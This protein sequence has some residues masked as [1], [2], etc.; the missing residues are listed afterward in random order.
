MKFNNGQDWKSVQSETGEFPVYGSGGKFGRATEF[1]HNGE[2]VL[3]GRKGTIDKPIY[4]DGKFWTVDTMFYATP[5]SKNTCVKYIYYWASTIEFVTISTNTALPSVTSTDLSQLRVPILSQ[6]EQVRIAHYLDRETAEIDAAVADLDRYVE[7][8]ATR[9]QLV[10]D[11]WFKFPLRAPS[12]ET[13]HSPTRLGLA[14]TLLRRGIS[15]KYADSGIPVVN[16]KCVRP[17]HFID[18]SNCR[19]HEKSKPI[20]PALLIQCGDI[21]INS[22]GT[23]TLGRS[24]LVQDIFEETTW[25]SHVTLLRPDR[26]VAHPKY[27]SWYIASQ[28]DRLIKLSTG[29]TNQIELSK[30][31]I[32]NLSLVLPSL[33]RQEEISD[34]I[35]EETSRIDSL[36]ADATKLRELLLKRRSV[37][38]T[39][40]VTGRKEV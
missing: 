31:T 16:Q 25:D 29:S 7:L 1:L 24:C 5:R 40:V 28:E 26:R 19:L 12:S 22:T 14:A 11:K 17:G 37:L 33:R 6:N 34:T 38:I 4:V 35:D 2:A 21:L 36:I 13:N 9:R 30:S 8:L 15:P 32:E 23:G 27:L 3:F 18:F 20:P 10:I 39:E